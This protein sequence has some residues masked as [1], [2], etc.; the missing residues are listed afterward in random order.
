MLHGLWDFSSPTRDQTWGPGSEA[1]SPNHWTARELPHVCFL[2]RPHM[3]PMIAP[4]I[5]SVFFTW[6]LLL[7]Q[8]YSKENWSSVREW[9]LPKGP[10]LA[11]SSVCVCVC[12]CVCLS[13]VRLFTTPWTVT[14]QAPLSMEFSRQEYWSGL[15]CPSPEQIVKLSFKGINRWCESSFLTTTIFSGDFPGGPVAKT[16]CSQCRRPRFNPWSGN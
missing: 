16:P 2:T 3:D 4:I 10:M 15:P 12:V 9:L 1:P 11:D 6:I 13:C 7:T 8:F 14:C 5:N